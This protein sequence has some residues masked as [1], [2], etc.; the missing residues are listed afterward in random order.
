MKHTFE[1]IIMGLGFVALPIVFISG[2]VLEKRVEELAAII[3]NIKESQDV[4]R[5]VKDQ[6]SK[7]ELQLDDKQ[8]KM[9][10]VYNR[11]SDMY[12]KWGES[13]QELF[14]TR[15]KL[16]NCENPPPPEKKAIKK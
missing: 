7:L 9:D 3:S 10:E 8:T 13:E 1:V 6:C 5:E 12:M 11:L 2:F 14:S 16:M 15:K 4:N